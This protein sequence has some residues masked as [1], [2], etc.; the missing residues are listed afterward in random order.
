MASYWRQFKDYHFCSPGNVGLLHQSVTGMGTMDGSSESC[1]S[2]LS[3]GVLWTA[4]QIKLPLFIC[5]A[6]DIVHSSHLAFSMKR[7]S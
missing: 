5:H 1:F 2:W 4:E 6:P 7:G 3:N